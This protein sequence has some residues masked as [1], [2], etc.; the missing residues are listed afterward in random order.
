PPRPRLAKTLAQQSASF[1]FALRVAQGLDDAAYKR[2]VVPANVHFEADDS[3]PFH[4]ATIGGEGLSFGA[5]HPGKP[6][7]KFRKCI[8]K[9]LPG[10]SCRPD[11]ACAIRGGV[12]R[13]SLAPRRAGLKPAPT[14]GGAR[15]KS[16]FAQH[17]SPEAGLRR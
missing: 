1:R 16:Q 4:P 11:C 3:L 13:M 7:L 9:S 14:C 17:R 10:Q 15:V 6:V 8:R 5:R 2:S 12:P